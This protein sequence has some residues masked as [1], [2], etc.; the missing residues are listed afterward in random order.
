[1]AAQ[2]VP[3]LAVLALNGYRARV[4][5]IFVSTGLAS[6]ATAL[7]ER[8]GDEGLFE[9]DEAWLPR[10]AADLD[11]LHLLDR[12]Q[13]EVSRVLNVNES[14]RKATGL[15]V[16]E[17][18]GFALRPNIGIRGLNPTRSTKVLLLEDG[19]CIRD[20][21][22]AVFALGEIDPGRGLDRVDDPVVGPAPCVGVYAGIVAPARIG[23]RVFEDLDADGV[24]TVNALLKEHLARGGSVLLGPI[25]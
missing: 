24:H 17:E 16:R 20:Q 6:V 3:G 22:L 13:L 8:H 10:V 21:A 14:L 4:T 15:N 1:M 23:D 2:N 12:A 19:H 11:P 9:V 7:L 18:E 25:M 5:P